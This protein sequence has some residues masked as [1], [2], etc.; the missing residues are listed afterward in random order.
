[1][2][3]E[4]VP[5]L[6]VDLDPDTEDITLTDLDPRA[7][8]WERLADVYAD[9]ELCP[10]CMWNESGTNPHNGLRYRECSC[11]A[12]DACPGVNGRSIANALR[13]QAS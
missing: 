12:P 5:G 13:R 4:P 2:K 1:M 8:A 6:I 9:G 3:T 11:F 10:A 7:D